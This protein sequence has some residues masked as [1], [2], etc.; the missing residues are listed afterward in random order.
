MAWMKLAWMTMKCVWDET[1]KLNQYWRY[2]ILDSLNVN[3]I[4]KA[5]E[6]VLLKL[7]RECSLEQ[8]GKMCKLNAS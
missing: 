7:S 3:N 4:S 8:K 5:S 2:H 1:T 6:H